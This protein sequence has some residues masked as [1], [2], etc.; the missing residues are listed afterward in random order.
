MLDAAKSI[1]VFLSF[2]PLLRFMFLGT[3]KHLT[4]FKTVA[5]PV[6][7]VSVIIDNMLV[8]KCG[9]KVCNMGE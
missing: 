7:L 5:F 2:I 1:F 9:G 8:G 6:N 4:A 3:L